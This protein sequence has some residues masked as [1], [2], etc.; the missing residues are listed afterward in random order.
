[1]KESFDILIS[2]SF[3]IAYDWM[4]F[5]A[6]YSITKHLPKSRVAIV[7]NREKVPLRLYS[8]VY[9]TPVR[10]LI[11]KKTDRVQQIC[12][13][14][15]EKMVDFPFVFIDADAVAVRGL[16]GKLLEQ[17]NQKN[18]N[19]VD[20]KANPTAYW[21]NQLSKDLMS[22]LINSKEASMEALGEVS[23]APELA[24]EASENRS[25]VFAS[26]RN[27][28]GNFFKKDYLDGKKLPPFKGCYGLRT[29]DMSSNERKV[30]GLW[31]KMSLLYEALN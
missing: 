1:M 5:S 20:S 2:S 26:C 14:L 24:G 19:F 25:I 8:W 15:K 31:E 28:C 4:C 27:K 7:C 16:S 11:H 13:A 10:F 3:D 30:F 17:L 29:L 23:E 9:R 6:W 12:Y 22:G 21:F 18:V